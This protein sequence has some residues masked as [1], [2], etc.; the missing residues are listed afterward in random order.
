MVKSPAAAVLRRGVM[1]KVKRM[2]S[3]RIVVLAIALVAGGLAAYLVASGPAPQTETVTVT[4]QAETA[5]VLVAKTDIGIGVVINEGML[6]WQPWPAGGTSGGM[7]R[8]GERPDAI[9]QVNGMIARQAFIAG[10]PIRDQKLVSATGSGFMAAILPTGK[11]ALSAEVAVETTAGGFVLPNDHVDVIL[12]VS[13]KEG[14]NNTFRSQ[15]ILEN[16][17]VLAVDQ[18]VEDK[19]GQRS[20]IGRTATVEVDPAQA[21]IL[22]NARH[23]GKLSL[24]LRSWLDG[25]KTTQ[26]AEPL[27][28]RALSIVRFGTNAKK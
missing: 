25:N 7:I 22:A 3:A 27:A 5:D 8:R 13:R 2:N 19:D 16:I 1:W 24:A 4:Q 9:K 11:R 18:L 12:T 6:Q 23:A 28:S 15:T 20:V 14:E 10:E 21:E 26:D 17:R